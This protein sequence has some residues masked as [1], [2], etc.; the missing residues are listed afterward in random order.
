MKFNSNELLQEDQ[1]RQESKAVENYQM[2]ENIR[3]LFSDEPYYI[4]EDFLIDQLNQLDQRNQYQQMMMSFQEHYY[5]SS[6]NLK[7]C[8]DD[9]S[10]IYSTP[11]LERENR[12]DNKDIEMSKSNLLDKFD[13]VAK[14]DLRQ[15]QSNQDSLSSENSRQIPSSVMTPYNAKPI[16]QSNS[17]SK[18]KE[19]GWC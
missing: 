11:S 19:S 9:P 14:S 7:H 17:D 12:W 6:L 4:S 3:K 8:D 1:T 15:L 2:P 5:E 13:E 16:D 18:E 10:L